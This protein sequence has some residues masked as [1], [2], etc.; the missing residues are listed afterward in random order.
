MRLQRI[1]FNH[2]DIPPSCCPP[3]VI[4]R[5][6][7]RAREQRL[8]RRDLEL[9]VFAATEQHGVGTTELVGWQK[10]APSV[11]DVDEDVLAKHRVEVLDDSVPAAVTAL[12]AQR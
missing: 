1:S 10:P 5:P 4:T 9:G 8:A 2:S 6:E 11:A 7:S 3:H 12:R